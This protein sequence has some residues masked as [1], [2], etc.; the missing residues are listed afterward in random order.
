MKFSDYEYG[1]DPNFLPTLHDEKSH[2]TQGG[3]K[4]QVKSLRWKPFG[5]VIPGRGQERRAFWRKGRSQT[6]VA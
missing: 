4:G 1:I 2:L 5:E 6:F 3:P